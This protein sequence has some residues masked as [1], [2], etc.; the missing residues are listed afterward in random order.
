MLSQK[1]KIE[2]DKLIKSYDSKDNTQEIRKLKHSKQ[3]R[4]DV[5]K[6]IELKKKYSRL[7][8][9]SIEKMAIKQANFLWSKYTNIFIK[10][11]KDKLNVNTLYQ[12]ISVLEMIEDG[13]LDQNEA[14]VQVGS[15]L[16]KLYIDSALYENKINT[17][18]N[19]KKS[20]KTKRKVKNIS[21][22]DFKERENLK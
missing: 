4:A 12:F 8:Y 18:N 21:W 19:D 6:I 22:K 16:K 7:K 1:E 14:S 3:I 5:A 13:K 20:K 11:M 15:I 2:L 9:E 10:L 17:K